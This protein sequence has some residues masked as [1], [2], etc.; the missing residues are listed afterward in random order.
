MVFL[1]GCE[2]WFLTLRK[3]RRLSVFEN[4]VLR[5]E[6]WGKRDEETK[7]GENLIMKSLMT[8]SAHPIMCG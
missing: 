2:P 5:R 8:R 3:K 7:T 1:Y 4:R 6:F